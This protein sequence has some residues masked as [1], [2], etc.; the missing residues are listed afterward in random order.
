MSS[1]I[2]VY[3]DLKL[4]GGFRTG[5]DRELALSEDRQQRLAERRDRGQQRGDLS[6]AQ[7][8][9]RRSTERFEDRL[10]LGESGLDRELAAAARIRGHHR[11]HQLGQRFA[12]RIEE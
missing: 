7:I 8:I 10:H 11:E 2:S 9:V 12:G 6:A 5:Q 1:Y 3:L 4:C